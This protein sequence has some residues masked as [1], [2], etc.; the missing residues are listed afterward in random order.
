MTQSSHVSCSPASVNVLR[1]VTAKRAFLINRIM[2][3]ESYICNYVFLRRGVISEG[4]MH[5]ARWW[6]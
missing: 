3:K 5:A 2:S 6:S 4:H 1:L